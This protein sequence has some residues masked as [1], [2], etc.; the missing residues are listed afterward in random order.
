MV[1]FIRCQAWSD[2]DPHNPLW[3]PLISSKNTLMRAAVLSCVQA[4]FSLLVPNSPRCISVCLEVDHFNR[5]FHTLS[6]AIHFAD[7][8]TNALHTDVKQPQMKVK[9]WWHMLMKGRQAGIYGDFKMGEVESTKIRLLSWTPRQCN[10][11][12]SWYH[13]G[14][15]CHCLYNMTVTLEGDLWCRGN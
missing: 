6:A 8:K 12:I 13:T 4:S 7:R 3:E 5:H 9:G 2:W 14:T 11:T 10:R 1:C 15:S